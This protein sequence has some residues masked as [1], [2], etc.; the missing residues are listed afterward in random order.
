MKRHFT[1]EEIMDAARQRDE[2]E[3]SNEAAGP[4]SLAALEESRKEILARLRVATNALRDA[5][6]VTHGY[7]SAFFLV[8]PPLD[9]APGAIHERF[10]RRRTTPIEDALWQK[11]SAQRFAFDP[12]DRARLEWCVNDV[13]R[14]KCRAL[15]ELFDVD[16]DGLWSYTDFVEYRT[17]IEERLGERPEVCAISGNEEVWRMYT[18]D[19]LVTDATSHHLTFDGFLRYREAI[20]DA[21]PLIYDLQAMG[22]SLEWRVV[23]KARRVLQLVGEYFGRD[24]ALPLKYVQFLLAE[25]GTVATYRDLWQTVQLQRLFHR[26]HRFVLAQKRALRMFGYKQKTAI[27]LTSPALE[28]DTRVCRAGLLALV[29]SAWMPMERTVRGV[30]NDTPCQ[31][32]CTALTGHDLL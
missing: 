6:A 10:F 13:G 18:T 19:V 14:E 28:E 25:C 20:E 9:Y 31:R 21:Y 15:W 5:G 11:L 29:F 17:A 4:R 1:H 32:N 7:D 24:D 23:E 12:P 8:P 22:V 27:Q 16:G 26:C 30:L 2:D 3:D